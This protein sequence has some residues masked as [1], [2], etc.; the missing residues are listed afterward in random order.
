[1]SYKQQMIN[2]KKFK[3]S[4]LLWY[5]NTILHLFGW[6][7]VLEINKDPN[8]EV[9]SAYP[10]RVSFR[11]FSEKDNTEGYIK[12]SDYLKDNMDDL[13]KEAKN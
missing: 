13:D 11:G 5:I 1:M 6:A 8:G 7:I 3:D 4:G 12:V 9:F 2:W 10:Q